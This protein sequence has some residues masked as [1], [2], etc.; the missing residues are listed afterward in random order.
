MNSNGASISLVAFFLI[1]FFVSAAQ[2]GPIITAYGQTLCIDGG[3]DGTSWDWEMR[4]EGGGTPFCSGTESVSGTEADIVTAIVAAINGCATNIGAYP[5]ATL[6]LSCPGGMTACTIARGEDSV[7]F[8]IAFEDS[9]NPGNL[10]VLEA[11]LLQFNPTARTAEG[12]D[13]PIACNG[14]NPCCDG[15]SPPADLCRNRVYSSAS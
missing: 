2:A 6:G 13:K 1:L 5:T 15:G 14:S 3:G 7:R 11:N 4:P 8:E 9:T 12:N 10:E